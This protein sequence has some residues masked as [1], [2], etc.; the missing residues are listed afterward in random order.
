VLFDHRLHTHASCIKKVANVD[1]VILLIGSRFG[2]AATPQALDE[3]SFEE[4]S[5]SSSMSSHIKENDKISITQVEIM[6]A[7]ECDIPLFAFVD[8][9]VYADHLLY[10][11]NKNKPFAKEITY[12][13]IDRP[14]TATYIFEF[15][16]FLTHRFA[17]NAIISYA[18]F[19]DI[20]D[21]LLKQWSLLFQRLLRE[22]RDKSVE[23]RRSDAILEQIQD[24]KAAVV[25]SMSAGAARDIAKNVLKYRRLADFLLAIRIYD[26]AVDIVS[27]SGSFDDLLRQFGVVEVS[28]GRDDRSGLLRTF[29]VLSDSSR[30]MVRIPDRR[31]L[32]F[33]SEWM[34]FSQLDKD[35]KL[36]VIEGVSESDAVGPRMIYPADYFMDD[37]QDLLTADATVEV[38]LG[39]TIVSSGWTDERIEL[40]KKMW[41]DGATASTIADALG[42]ISRNAVIG[43]AHRL[44]L[45]SRPMP[46]GNDGA[47]VST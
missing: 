42:N 15:I 31:F 36:A 11:K 45:L 21:H 16:N 6:K 9:K 5:K 2:G 8:S 32:D 28:G 12:P 27:F 38:G 19:S 35:T 46:N 14:E 29:L 24:L 25:Q 20:E 43:K 13:S 37:S 10:Q 7:I 3:I 18:N 22:E 17:N 23:S 30:L 34:A 4:I 1:M 40:L 44:G 33:Y 26:T 41:A 47:E 39:K